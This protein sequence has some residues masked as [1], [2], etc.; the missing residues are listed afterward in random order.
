MKRQSVPAWASPLLVVP[1]IAAVGAWTYTAIDGVMRARLGESLKASAQASAS[2]LNLW[3]DAQADAADIAAA[4][5]RVR[6][7]DDLIA[8]VAMR[9]DRPSDLIA[10]SLGGA[11]AIRLALAHPE[12]VRRLVLTA[13]SGGMAMRGF[14]ASDW[15]EEYRR[16]FPQAAEWVM[17]PFPDLSADLPS[18]RQ[19]VLLLWGDDD[20]ISPVA[21]GDYLRE[22]LPDARLHVAKGGGHDLAV[23]HAAEIAPL[24]ANFLEP[25]IDAD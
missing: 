1:V 22:R 17:T 3:L 23:T 5:P 25:R 2:T 20:P 10:Q 8:L 7:Y 24:I 19:P 11:L 4:D 14:G 6:G 9:L 16:L 21:A 12:K 18:L 15:R 13:T